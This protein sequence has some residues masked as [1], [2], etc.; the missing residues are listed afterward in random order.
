MACGQERLLLVVSRK[1]VRRVPGRSVVADL[2]I[3]LFGATC[4][5][6]ERKIFQHGMDWYKV[7]FGPGRVEVLL[8]SSV[9]I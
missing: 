9:A 6:A 2:S 8:A 1:G 7:I 5:R 4:D 3:S